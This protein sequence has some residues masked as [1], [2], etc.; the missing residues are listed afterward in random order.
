MGRLHSLYFLLILIGPA[1]AQVT[2]PNCSAGWEWVSVSTFSVYWLPPYLIVVPLPQ[3]VQHF[4]SKPV[5][6]CRILGG[7]V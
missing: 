1:L 6:R 5:Q 3:V 2:Y 4:E 7:F